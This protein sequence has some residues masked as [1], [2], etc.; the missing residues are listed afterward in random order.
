MLP[1]IAFWVMGKSEYVGDNRSEI[2]IFLLHIIKL[3]IVY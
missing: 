3:Y 1:K 2:L